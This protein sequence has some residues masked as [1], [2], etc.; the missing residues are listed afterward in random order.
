MADQ[1]KPFSRQNFGC[2]H[3]IVG[4][5]HTG[6]GNFY[7]PYDSQKIF[8]QFPDIGVKIIPFGEIFYSKEKRDYVHYFG[9]N[10]EKEIG[11]LAISGSE[12]RRMLKSGVMPPSWMI[13]E[14]ISKMIL[15]AIKN[16]EEVF[17]E[18]DG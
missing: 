5:D 13:R 11:S 17:V 10:T 14:E 7:G 18:E 2:N 8:E 4:R 15:E 6:V 1:E 16:G 9:D 12:V 3:F